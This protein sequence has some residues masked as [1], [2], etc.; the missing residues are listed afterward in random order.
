LGN[1]EPVPPVLQSSSAGVLARYDDKPSYSGFYFTK[2]PDRRCH[3]SRSAS[4]ISMD[5][6]REKQEI[7]DQLA[8]YEALALQ[9][10]EGPTHENIRKQIED[11]KRRLRAVER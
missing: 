6:D 3:F 5:K 8:R 10:S 2:R 9:F 1:N 4:F 11:L 7:Q